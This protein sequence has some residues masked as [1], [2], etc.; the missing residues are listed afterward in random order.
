MNNNYFLICVKQL[1]VIG[2]LQEYNIRCDY[3]ITHYVFFTEEDVLNS[4]AD[5]NEHAACRLIVDQIHGCWE[6]GLKLGVPMNDLQEI[7]NPD[8]NQQC[9]RSEMTYK[10]LECWNRK[11]VEPNKKTWNCIINAIRLSGN[12]SLARDVKHSVLSEADKEQA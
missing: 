5:I 11:T 9:S 2:T 6:F 8:Q 10:I 7:V 3:D 1:E 4:Q 12:D